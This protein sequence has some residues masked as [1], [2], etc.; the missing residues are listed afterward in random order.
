MCG[1]AG[2][3]AL[4]AGLP[5]PRIVDLK[6]MIGALKHRGPDSFGVYRDGRVGFAHARLSII[7]LIGGGQPMSNARETL[8]VVFNGEIFN[9]L[10]LR[11]ELTSLGQTFRTESDTEVI[12]N[13]YDEWGDGAFE[14]FNG[15]FALVLRD[16]EHD[17]VVLARDRFGVEPLYV[18]EHAGR[19]WFASEV[20]AI[21]AGDREIRRE[22]DPVGLAETFTF[23]ST[24]APQTVFSGVDEIEPGH[25]RTVTRAGSRDR[26]YWMPSYPPEEER[27][28]DD[29]LAETTEK[30]RCALQGAVSLRM[31][32]SDVPVGSY[33]SGGLDSSLVAS[34]ARRATGGGFSTFSIRFEDPDYD[35][36]RYQRLMAEAVGG[37]HHEI[38]VRNRDICDVFPQVVAHLERP[39]LRT[40]PAP[41][42]LLSRLVRE[43][44]IKVVLTGEGADEMFG[45]YDLFRE[46]KVRRFWGRRPES[47]LRPR[48]LERLYPY[49]ARSP[50]DARAMAGEFFGRDRHRWAEAGF[51]HGPRWRSTASLFN[52]LTPQVRRAAQ[53]TDVT[54]RFLDS[55]PAGF[56]RWSFLAQDQYIEVR[57]FLSSYLLSAQGDRMLMSHSV[58]GRFP[59]LDPAVVTLAESLPDRLKLLGLQEKPLLKRVAMGL[60]PEAIISRSK[61]PYRSPDGR[62]FLGPDVP[63]WVRAMTAERRL[64][65]D[66]LFDAGAVARLLRKCQGLPSHARL[67]NVD[68]MALV[69]VLSTGL[70]QEALVIPSPRRWVPE[71]FD[72]EVDNAGVVYHPAGPRSIESSAHV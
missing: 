12:L 1:I 72:I 18:C 2:S 44:G 10:E 28:G 62:S 27:R 13:A 3:I 38:V 33:L 15:Q 54:S 7:D 53:A 52:L 68:N 57:T 25:A 49:L 39:I 61:Q 19:L 35:E 4:T 5:P 55:L 51:G 24:V 41:L 17:T 63:D 48:L 22:L 30:V 26:T 14:R 36:T 11:D 43:S 47:T 60:A 31:L 70:L 8:W 65:T 6:A 58:E 23:W 46:S 42:Y 16:V 67:S 66:G 69:A 45:G 56:R 21:F 71:R 32:R 37:S 64:V 40:A 20:K 34:L 29:S 50:V 9:Y 59:F